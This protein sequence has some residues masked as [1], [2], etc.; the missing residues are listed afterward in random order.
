MQLVHIPWLLR[1]CCSDD[2]EG[3]QQSC[4]WI[5]TPTGSFHCFRCW[6]LF[7]P[8]CRPSAEKGAVASSSTAALSNTS[9]N[10]GWQ[11]WL[12]TSASWS[13]V[14]LKNLGPTLA[15][16]CITALYLTLASGAF[17]CLWL[18]G[19][20]LVGCEDYPLWIHHE[21]DIC[22]SISPNFTPTSLQFSL[23]NMPWISCKVSSAPGPHHPWATWCLNPHKS[24]EGG[25]HRQ[26]WIWV[27]G[28]WLTNLPHM[29]ERKNYP[30]GICLDPFTHY[31]SFLVTLIQLG[32]M[33]HGGYI[34]LFNLRVFQIP[35][36]K[37]KESIMNIFE[38]PPF[39]ESSDWSLGA[40]GPH[41]PL[42][43]WYISQRTLPMSRREML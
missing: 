22:S 11:G 5:Q 8:L 1:N 32:L 6:N 39:L 14:L 20:V 42:R 31:G 18:D 29:E 9:S 26:S 36:I 28:S 27:A 35:E 12:V 40:L 38:P 33:F 2:M 24:K 37:K 23:P 34:Y 43:S 4:S 41:V 7:P 10:L 13:T 17:F 25:C 16:Q 21:R 19:G 30:L 15:A 3:S